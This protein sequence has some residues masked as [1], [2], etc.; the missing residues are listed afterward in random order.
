[1]RFSMFFALSFLAMLFLVLL[2]FQQSLKVVG[3]FLHVLLLLAVVVLF[4]LGAILGVGFL[5]NYKFIVLALLFFLKHSGDAL[6]DFFAVHPFVAAM[7]F[8]VSVILGKNLPIFFFLSH[9]K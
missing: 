2:L 6:A 9:F 3:L 1:M 7:S 5:L 4:R 8:P